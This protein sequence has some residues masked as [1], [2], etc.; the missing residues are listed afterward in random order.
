M[1]ISK[2]IVK[3]KELDRIVPQFDKLKK[4][5]QQQYDIL[6]TQ[7]F[8]LK[9]MLEKTDIQSLVY[10]FK[11]ELEIRMKQQ[12]I[13]FC[14]EVRQDIENKI[15]IDHFKERIKRRAP[16]QDFERL[17]EDHH[18]LKVYCHHELFSLLE[19]YYSELRVTVNR[20]TDKEELKSTIDNLVNRDEIKDV[21]KSVKEMESK[22]SRLSQEIKDVKYQATGKQENDMTQSE[23]DEIE[24]LEQE[25]QDEMIAE[26]SIDERNSNFAFG[27]LKQDS[28][29][30][31]QR[32]GLQMQN[33]EA[34]S[35]D[36]H[37]NF[38]KSQINTP[39]N[40]IQ[41]HF[42]QPQKVNQSNALI[43]SS[44]SYLIS[45][46][47]FN[48]GKHYSTNNFG[49]GKTFLKGIN[50]LSQK[51]MEFLQRNRDMDSYLSNSESFMKEVQDHL[52]DFKTKFQNLKVD[53]QQFQD[54]TEQVTS[55]YEFSKVQHQ[56]ILEEYEQIEQSVVIMK[57]E[58]KEFYSKIQNDTDLKFK[59]L[60]QIDT[61]LN[62]LKQEQDVMRNK[63]TK[64]DSMQKEDQSKLMSKIVKI[65]KSLQDQKDYL[66]KIQKEQELK[67]KQIESQIEYLR[68]PF[69]NDI[70]NIKNE[71]Q[72]LIRE[73]NR[74]QNENREMLFDKPYMSQSILDQK[75]YNTIENGSTD[76]KGSIE[77]FSGSQHDTAKQKR[78]QS[79]NKVLESNRSLNK[80][81]RL[82]NR[83]AVTAISHR[84]PQNYLTH[85]LI[86]GSYEQSKDQQN[87]PHTPIVQNQKYLQ[88][89]KSGLII[90]PNNINDMSYQNLN[91][92]SRNYK[93]FMI[94]N[95]SRPKSSTGLG[96]FSGQ[97]KIKF[98]RNQG[99]LNFATTDALQNYTIQNQTQ[100]YSIPSEKHDQKEQIEIVDV[101]D[102][103]QTQNILNHN[104]RSK[105]NQQRPNKL[106]PQ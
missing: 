77:S 105:F 31:S 35:G 76:N 53:E 60:V 40:L 61:Q 66:L 79:I 80:S 63:K 58:M 24:K 19:G 37:K 1:P 70:K 81:T 33:S 96:N 12:F 7:E 69:F 23:E 8:Q 17:K 51:I 83:R 22:I 47:N 72:G 16:L 32:L 13:D 27:V 57:K 104:L 2:I 82:T 98:R 97:I 42:E 94:R 5:M 6:S 84:K 50:E 18:A 41:K 71:N 20:K 11:T 93:G 73:L 9:N 46:R 102:E 45:S 34:H 101:N 62:M 106:F 10:E 30:E 74:T 95:T 59:K 68:G 44:R 28:K 4:Q 43:N 14:Q 15:D 67:I 55:Y 64:E 65:D 100:N 90:T 86:P 48:A 89:K 49:F 78:R 92:E 36:T 38:D 91:Q 75:G 52:Q 26:S 87:I 54:K 3:L 21:W 99:E 56:K 39:Q 85:I 103:T 29:I 88:S 25:L